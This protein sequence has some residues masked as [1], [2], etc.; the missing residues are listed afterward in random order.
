MPPRSRPA[1]LSASMLSFLAL[2]PWMAFMYRAWPR[3]KG[4]FSRAQRSASQY[5]ANMHST[6]TTRSS[7]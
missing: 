4:M 3:T 5:Q 7:R 1:I 6:A 2:P